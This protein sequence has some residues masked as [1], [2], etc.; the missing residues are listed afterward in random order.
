LGRPKDRPKVLFEQKVA[1]VYKGPNLQT[2][3]E[4]TNALVILPSKRK[5]VSVRTETV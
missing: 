2:S 4:I 5:P 3:E 1:D